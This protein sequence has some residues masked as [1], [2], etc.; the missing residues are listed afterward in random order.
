MILSSY[1][2]EKQKIAWPS[3]T[4]LADDALMSERNCRY[5]LRSLEAKG[6][7]K[8]EFGGGDKSNWYRLPLVDNDKEVGQSLPRGWG[9]N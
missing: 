1:Y 3:V 9:N 8:T 4:T 7:I 2:N 6:L 5:L